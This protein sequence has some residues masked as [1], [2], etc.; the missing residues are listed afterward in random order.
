MKIFIVP[1]VHGSLA[2]KAAEDKTESVD[3]IVFLGDYFDSWEKQ[4]PQQGQNFAEIC[5]F[6]RSNPAK[7]VLLI[8]NHDWSYLSG[9]R[10]GENC[11]GHQHSHAREIR[12]LLAQNKDIIDLAFEAGGWVFSHAGF[13]K[14]WVGYMR[15]VF[16]E[17][18]SCKEWSISLLN[19]IWHE[20]SHNPSDKNF[21]YGFDE[22][23]DWHGVFSGCGDEVFQGCLW[24]RPSS[25]LDDA[26]YPKQLVGH[27]E[28]CLEDFVALKKNKNIAV[29]ADSREHT[30]FGIFD[31]DKFDESRAMTELE[32]NRYYKK[33]LKRINDEKSRAGQRQ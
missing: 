29:I 25:L 24:I 8:G 19:K 17:N 30:P 21:C 31:T 26:F 20:R 22:L 6:K 27:S 3:K 2:W 12:A 28:Y 7:V 1:D 33:T 23:L 10:D 32:F 13:S 11:S 14:T 18:F 15:E 5:E 4:W 9:T 16:A